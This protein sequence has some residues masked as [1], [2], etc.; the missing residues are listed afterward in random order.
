MQNCSS[1]H[2]SIWEPLLP[3]TSVTYSMAMGE[4]TAAVAACRRGLDQRK[5]RHLKITS[6]PLVWLWLA[7]WWWWRW[8]CKQILARARRY[9]HY[10]KKPA[11]GSQRLT[12]VGCRARV[13]G[14]DDDG[15]W[16]NGRE[17]AP[18][19]VSRLPSVANRHLRSPTV[20][21]LRPAFDSPLRMSRCSERY[22]GT[23]CEMRRPGETC[24]LN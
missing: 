16:N 3:S 7:G 18:K 14:G 17:R 21:A 6:I 13:E 12:I 11:P 19:G 4:G 15:V 10:R 23:R 1:K 20:E 2:I 8:C 9:S 5:E 24:H 22:R